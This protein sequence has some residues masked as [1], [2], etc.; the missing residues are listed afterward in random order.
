MKKSLNILKVAQF[1]FIV[2][3]TSLHFAY[4]Q[5]SAQDKKAAQ[6][7]AV[8]TL[9]DSKNF[10][11]E[12]QS[13][14]PASGGTRQLTPYYNLKVFGDTLASE[15]PYFG[16]AYV[17]PINPRQSGF[18]FT[19]TEFDY[20]VSNRKKGGW[21][22]NIKPKDATI[23]VREMVL[24]IFDNGSASLIVTSNNRQPISYY[25]YIRQRSDKD[26]M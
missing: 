26:K 25:G 1:I 5:E 24:T 11:F 14:N 16:R 8:K 6:I 9:I 15:L 18:S 23:D 3:V 7:T 17:A 21:D 10:V 12:V 22:I 13:V 20:T 2:A 19:T 4:A